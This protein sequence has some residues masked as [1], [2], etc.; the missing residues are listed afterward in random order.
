[1]VEFA[2]GGSADLV[3]LS[4]VLGREDS[5]VVGHSLAR[6]RVRARRV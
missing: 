3:V 4:R 6:R 1:M 5:N 2:Q